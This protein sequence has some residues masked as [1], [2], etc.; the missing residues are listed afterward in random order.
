MYN[1]DGLYTKGKYKT[2]QLPYIETDTN[3]IVRKDTNHTYL[4]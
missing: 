2:T 1:D 3:Y 4:S